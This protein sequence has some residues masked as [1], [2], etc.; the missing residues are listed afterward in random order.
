M[1]ASAVIAHTTDGPADA[2][3]V[4]LLHSLGSDA[5]MWQPQADALA[6]DHLVVRVESRGHG[7]A[8]SPTGPYALAD[9]GGDVIDVLDDLGLARVHLAGVSLGGLTA[10]WLATR[11]PDR[12]VSLTAANTAA[13]V[14]TAEGWQAR[15]DAVGAH[16]LAGIRDDVLARFF[17]PGFATAQPEAFAAAQRAF[18]AADDEGYA[19][20]CAALAEADLRPAVGSITIP[21]LVIGGELDVATP[22]S[23]ALALH[24]AIPGSRLV[25]LAGAAHLSNLDQPEAFTAALREHIAVAES[26][27]TPPANPA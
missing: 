17:A 27:A 9:L 16:G 26:A 5:S 23:D 11:H 19:A 21:T 6:A 1:S 18:T 8:P 14:G 15:I 20:C 3:A 13:R 2:P 22:P 25:L 24:R 7:R 12:L 10:L 4:V